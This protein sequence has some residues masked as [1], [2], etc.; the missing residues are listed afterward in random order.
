MSHNDCGAAHSMGVSDAEVK[1]RHA[2]F[3]KALQLKFPHIPVH[4]MH[5]MHSE[6]GEHHHGYENLSDV[7]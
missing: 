7:A 3:A 5:D 4:V 2:A 6:C 1:R